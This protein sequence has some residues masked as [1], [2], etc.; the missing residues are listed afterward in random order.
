MSKLTTFNRLPLPEQLKVASTVKN[1]NSLDE[2]VNDLSAF[3]PVISKTT[4]NRIRI[5]SDFNK[6]SI[7]NRRF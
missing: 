6:F 1:Y 5:A 7:S 3:N 2:L 4:R